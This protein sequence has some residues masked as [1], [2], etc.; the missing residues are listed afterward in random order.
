MTE[1]GRTVW[2]SKRGPWLWRVER[3]NG[4]DRI[5]YRAVEELLPDPADVMSGEMRS[6]AKHSTSQS[7]IDECERW[8]RERVL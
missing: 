6:N 4:G 2:Q 5:R 8:R 7:A 1:V 3:L